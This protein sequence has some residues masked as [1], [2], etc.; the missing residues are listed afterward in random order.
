MKQEIYRPLDLVTY[1]YNSLSFETDKEIPELERGFRMVKL[2]NWDAALDIF[3]RVTETYPNSPLIH[4][5][6]YNLGLG[7]MYTDQFDQAR[8]AL[9]QAYARKSEGK[10]LKA[11]E[12]LNVRIEDKRR[13]EEQM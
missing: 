1:V 10:Y 2:G 3:Q 5:A 13:L 11:I 12:K 8:T 4:K 7:Y 6:Y 9:E